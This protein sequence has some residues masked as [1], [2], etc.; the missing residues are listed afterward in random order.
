MK[1]NNTIKIYLIFLLFQASCINSDSNY[2]IDDN[3]T[4]GSKKNNLEKCID[5]DSYNLGY[6]IARDQ[7]QLV[8]DC[9]YLFT[10]AQTQKD[11]I[12]KYCFC[13]GV[14]EYRNNK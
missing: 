5:M 9:D 2:E 11:N 7:R 13:K 1:K 14:E 10:L 12:N 8:A 6:D 3:S 4:F